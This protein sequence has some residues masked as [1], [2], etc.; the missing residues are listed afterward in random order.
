MR[1][2]GGRSAGEN[3]SV[4]ANLSTE[5]QLD[6]SIC[7][8]LGLG[9]ETSAGEGPSMLLQ[10]HS[11]S[12]SS[13]SI[14]IQES[15]REETSTNGDEI[16]DFSTS[17]SL[18]AA[19]RDQS[20]SSAS[21]G[22]LG[23]EH[24]LLSPIP[25]KRESFD[26]VN[27]SLDTEP[28]VMSVLSPATE[29][30]NEQSLSRSSAEGSLRSRSRSRQSVELSNEQDQDENLMG[31][32]IEQNNYTAEVEEISIHCPAS[33]SQRSVEPTDEVEIHTTTTTLPNSEG[34]EQRHEQEE[35]SHEE[36]IFLLPLSQNEQVSKLDVSASNSTG[37]V[38]N[39]SAERF[40]WLEPEH[41]TDTAASTATDIKVEEA[42]VESTMANETTSIREPKQTVQEKSQETL[43]RQ[44]YSYDLVSA[45]KHIDASS[46]MFIERLRGAAHRRKLEVTRSRDSLAAKEQQQLISNAASKERQRQLLAYKEEHAST[47]SIE[48]GYKP[49]KARPMVQ[50]GSGG[51]VGV[52]KVEKK[53][54]TTPFSPQL[55]AKRQQRLRVPA[56]EKGHGGQFGVPKVEKKKTTVPVSPHLGLR[57]PPQPAQTFTRDR[58]KEKRRDKV[59]QVKPPENLMVRIDA[60]RKQPMVGR[61]ESF[62]S[63]KNRPMPCLNYSYSSS[64]SS[65]GLRGLDFLSTLS[66][67]SDSLQ[68][69]ALSHENTAPANVT[70]RNS[71]T[72][73]Y[74]PHSTE[75][76]KKR[77]D[78]DAHRVE[79]EARRLEL[80]KATRESILVEKRQ[81]ANKLRGSL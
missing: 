48:Q 51:Q 55:G 8:S 36:S 1:S 59:S 35:V 79:N 23:D 80:A 14:L 54:T 66:S 39:S 81:E 52:P 73:G 22:F 50:S 4:R 47:V 72:S 26:E 6:T 57:R 69:T 2:S 65:A 41:L 70:P 7:T 16:P 29:A 17:R 24:R 75:R 53:P 33:T 10:D 15:P 19:S 49:F 21:I 76:A 64:D 74:I 68:I 61:R 9:S 34:I 40:H 38:G 18:T 25:L 78:F 32:S 27:W 60:S 20:C 30:S 42:R 11:L 43:R 45:K 13:N 67:S 31:E 3:G 77:A 58:N 46:L 5:L 28:I 63:N 44:S 71:K 12:F 56:L 37:S 62:E